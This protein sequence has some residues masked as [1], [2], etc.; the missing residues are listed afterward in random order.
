LMEIAPADDRGED[1]VYGLEA[2]RD[3]ARQVRYHVPPRLASSQLDRIASLALTAYRLLGCRDI[4]RIDFRLDAAGTPHFIECNPLPGLSP[5][6]G[7]LVILAK[8][9]G[10]TY[11]ELIGEILDV[12]FAR[13]GLLMQQ[14]AELKCAS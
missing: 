14:R 8:A 1:F 4:A 11:R 7:D 6:K 2:K 3:F 13:Q 12:S 10:M 5:V 9:T